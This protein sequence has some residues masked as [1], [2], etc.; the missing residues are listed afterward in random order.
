MI[1]EHTVMG[2]RNVTH[3]INELPVCLP[4]GWLRENALGHRHL[5]WITNLLPSAPA[6]VCY[7]PPRWTPSG[8]EEEFSPEASLAPSHNPISSNTHSSAINKLEACPLRSTRALQ[9][10]SRHWDFCLIKYHSTA[11]EV[12]ANFKYCQQRCW[13][14]A[15]AV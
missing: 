7:S 10:S 6:A 12:K 2:W 3:A 9:S 5:G 1:W 15:W 8:W 11:V 13:K 14:S 4:K